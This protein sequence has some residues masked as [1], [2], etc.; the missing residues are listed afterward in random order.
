MT[1]ASYLRNALIFVIA[2]SLGSAIM[3]PLFPGPEFMRTELDY[4]EEHKD[5]YDVLFLGSSVIRRGIIPVQFDQEM[6]QLGREVKSFNLAIPGMRSHEVNYFL[7]QV[8]LLKPARLQLVVVELDRF[9]PRINEVNY[10][11][12]RMVFWH[13]LPQTLLVLKSIRLERGPVVDQL[14][15]TKL[16]TELLGAK[17]SSIGRGPSLV[18]ELR[19]EWVA[20]D[21]LKLDQNRGWVPNTEE[22]MSAIGRTRMAVNRLQFLR[23][24]EQYDAALEALIQSSKAA[25]SHDEFNFDAL[26]NRVENANAHGVRL[27]HVLAPQLELLPNIHR[28]LANGLIKQT[29]NYHSPARFPSLYSKPMRFDKNHL[30]TTGAKLWTSMLARDIAAAWSDSEK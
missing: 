19:G 7:E 28:A 23:E 18:N 30:N 10:L 15:R 20:Q 17:M 9:N 22:E 27:L 4:F 5:E 1:F 12:P 24:P 13:D 2:L 16:H 6:A 11:A 21:D 26:E 14:K 3:Y 25:A 29:L 8:L